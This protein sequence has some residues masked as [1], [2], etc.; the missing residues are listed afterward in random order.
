[1]L[2]LL[3]HDGDGGFNSGSIHGA[4][5]GELGSVMRV[6][7]AGRDGGNRRARM[8]GVKARETCA[9]STATRIRVSI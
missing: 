1:M 9:S 5:V 4:L 2:F 3:E 8:L 6:L 7:R